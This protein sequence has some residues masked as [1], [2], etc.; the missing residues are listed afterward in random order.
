MACRTLWQRAQHFS[1]SVQKLQRWRAVGCNAQN[2]A[3][4]S[5]AVF[6]LQQRTAV[7]RTAKHYALMVARVRLLELFQLGSALRFRTW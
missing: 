2:D 1:G 7:A 5:F 4:V 3:I 6:E